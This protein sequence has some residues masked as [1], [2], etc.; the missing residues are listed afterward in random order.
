MESKLHACFFISNSIYT[1]KG[2]VAIHM[3]QNNSR[4]S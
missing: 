3:Q 2:C 1:G 4:L